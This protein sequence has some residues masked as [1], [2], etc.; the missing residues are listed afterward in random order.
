MSN[1]RISGLGCCLL[2]RIYDHVDFRSEAFGTYM[3]R[4]PGDGGLEPGK[5]TFEEEL[6]QF[7]GEPFS[8][9][10]LPQLVEGRK[11]D[12]E[13]IG[14]PCIVALINASQ[15]AWRES[16]VSFYGC[17]GDDDVATDLL[18]RLSQTSVDLTHY[19]TQKGSE[20]PSTSVLSD[21]DYDNGN[22][23]RTFVNIIGASWQYMPEEVDDSFYDS[24]ICV[25]GGT[26]LV[27][28]IHHSLSTMLTKARQRGGITIVNT[29]YDSLSEKKNPGQRWPMGDGDRKSVV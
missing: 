5:L 20:T 18:Q 1:I 26:A 10:I 2:D 9:H 17:R 15:L 3:S 23:E 14:G 4:T 12:K 19:R 6:E 27:P 28:R 24:D 16:T 21:P 13:N 29:V 25:F 11:P 8:T 22:G 7:A